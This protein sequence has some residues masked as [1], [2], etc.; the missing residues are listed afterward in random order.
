MFILY[1]GLIFNID[2]PKQGSGWKIYPPDLFGAL[3]DINSATEIR[4]VFESKSFSFQ[5]LFLEC[6]ECNECSAMNMNKMNFTTSYTDHLGKA[7]FI[8]PKIGSITTNQDTTLTIGLNKSL[9][10]FMVGDMYKCI[11][12]LRID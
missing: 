3:K 5:E 11:N 1:S 4:N 2:V 10:F 6:N 8:Q 12:V 9:N 7:Y